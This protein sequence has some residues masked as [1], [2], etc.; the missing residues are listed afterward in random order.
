LPVPKT[1]ARLA[2]TLLGL[3]S[4]ALAV[5]GCPETFSQTCPSGAHNEGTFTASFTQV[6]PNPGEC[7]V[8]VTDADGGTTDGGLLSGTPQPFQATLCSQLL[9]DGGQLLY[10]AVGTSGIP[11]VSPVGPGAT[12]AFS[13]AATVTGTKCV[14]AIDVAETISG[15]LV[16]SSGADGGAVYDADAGAFEP[17]RGFNSLVVDAVD[18][19]AGCR[20][21][22]PCNVQYTLNATK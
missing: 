5:P 3:L 4:L 15:A 18:G 1:Q 8:F 13:S 7:R 19:G 9:G 12:F 22:V 2:L 14:C 6:T 17:L 10:M 16:P 21:N 20:C 11:R